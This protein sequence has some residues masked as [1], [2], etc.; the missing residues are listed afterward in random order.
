MNYHA[1][2]YWKSQEEKK[3]ALSTRVYLEKHGCVL[4]RVWDSPKG[5]HPLPMFQI[6]Y[7]SSNKKKIEKYLINKNLTILLHEDIGKDHIRDHTIGARWIGA[8]LSLDLEF[9]KNQ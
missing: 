9:L 3:L 8:P 7:N 4:G 6:K 2:I 5:P 1:H